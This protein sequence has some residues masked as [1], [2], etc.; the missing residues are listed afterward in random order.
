MLHKPTRRDLIKYG[1]GF[2]AAFLSGRR[3]VYGQVRIPGPGGS[4]P[5]S[6]SVVAIQGSPV[7][8]AYQGTSTTTF[9]IPVTVSAGSNLALTLTLNLATA[10]TAP[11]GITAVWDGGGQSMTLLMD[12]P[13]GGLGRQQSV[14]FGLRNP[15]VGTS[16]ITIAWTNTAEA[17]SSAIVLTGVSQ[18]S[19]ATA[20]PFAGRVG[21]G[22]D[23]SPVATAAVPSATGD[24]VIACASAGVSQGT[25]T[26]T[27]IFND[28]TSA[29]IINAFAN[30]DA[31]AASVT[32]GSSNANNVSLAAVDVAHA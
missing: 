12:Q 29:S 7:I 31:G 11:T 30:Y 27:L 15:T 24:I 10:T 4:A 1:G 28:H 20:F 25:P 13:N 9:T 8:G 5:A 18:T 6:G 26:G 3:N 22:T 21:A 17:L 19:D 32:I 14:I 23:S 2:G 16:T